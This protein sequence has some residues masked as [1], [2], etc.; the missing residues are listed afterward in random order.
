MPGQR[1]HRPC[2]LPFRGG[3]RRQRLL[4]A[5]QSELAILHRG[6]RWDSDRFGGRLAGGVV[7]QAG[8]GCTDRNHRFAAHTFCRLSAGGAVGRFR[9]SRRRDGRLLSRLAH[10]RNPELPDPAPGRTDLG[11][12]GIPPERFCLHP[13][14]TSIARSAARVV[15]PFHSHSP[16]R[17]VRARD[18]PGGDSHP[19]C[20]GFPRRL[21]PAAAL[22]E[23][24]RKGSLSLL[25]PRHPGCMDGNA[26]SG[27]PRRSIGA[28]AHHSKR[29]TLSEP[30]F[31]SVPCLHRDPGNPRGAR[32]E[33]PRP[34]PLSRHQG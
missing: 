30:R 15:R 34:H 21:S 26:R 12:G 2:G 33:P 7:S 1:C 18:Q 10:A 27:F 19:C 11:N 4:L 25:A 6:H 3:S 5:G 22:Q 29:L 31:D 8:G 32:L 23:N 9:R 24:P 16:A 20:L 17:L 14:R 13:H 28:A